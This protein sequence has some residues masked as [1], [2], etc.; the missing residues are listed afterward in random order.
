MLDIECDTCLYLSNVTLRQHTDSEKDISLP[1]IKE[2][3]IGDGCK[4]RHKGVVTRQSAGVSMGL[5]PSM[6]N[7]GCLVIVS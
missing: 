4:D 1:G 2:V 5:S 3:L 6:Q 7:K